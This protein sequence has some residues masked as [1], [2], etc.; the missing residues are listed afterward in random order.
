MNQ[1]LLK[2]TQN[3][4]RKAEVFVFELLYDLGVRSWTL[5]NVCFFARWI[6]VLTN[7][8]TS[9]QTRYLRITRLWQEGKHV[10]CGPRAESWFDPIVLLNKSSVWQIS[11]PLHQFASRQTVTIRM[12]KPGRHDPPAAVQPL[13]D[14]VEAET[15]AGEPLTLL[16]CVLKAVGF[17]EPARL[18]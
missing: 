4:R 5:N 17:L 1:L 6:Y 10:T 13:R 15:C 3:K 8:F 11:S 7:L 2:T 16:K 18:V 14:A 12:Q 9:W